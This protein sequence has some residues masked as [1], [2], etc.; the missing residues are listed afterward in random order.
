ME[1]RVL[2]ISLLGSEVCELHNELTVCS[3]SVAS[4]CLMLGSGLECV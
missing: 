4:L 3:L 1:V 2:Q